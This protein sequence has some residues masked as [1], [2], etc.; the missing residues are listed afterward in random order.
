MDWLVTVTYSIWQINIILLRAVVNGFSH[1][2]EYGF[3]S[4]YF[5]ELSIQATPEW[6]VM[7]HFDGF[8]W[9]SYKG[10]VF[11]YTIFSEC[12]I[13]T[14]H[15]FVLRG[16]R[17]EYAVLNVF[18]GLILITWTY[19]SDFDHTASLTFPKRVCLDKRNDC[20]TSSPLSLA[21]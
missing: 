3:Y 20:F 18:K 1:L 11:M 17:S 4:L 21:E 2:Y 5:T 9:I 14:E 19:S 13:C 16:N 8:L 12:C 6:I 15:S 7:W 10:N